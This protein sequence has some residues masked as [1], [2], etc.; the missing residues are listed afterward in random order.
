MG[1]VGRV[2]ECGWWIYAK[3]PKK[4]KKIEVA[5]EFFNNVIEEFTVSRKKFIHIIL[6]NTMEI[7]NLKSGSHNFTAGFTSVLILFS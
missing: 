3:N 2:V 6:Q 7:L 4:G 1:G 5:M